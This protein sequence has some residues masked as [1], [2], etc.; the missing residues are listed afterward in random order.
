[1]QVEMK[2]KGLMLDPVT[3]MPI[4]ILY[5]MEGQRILPIH[6]AH[7]PN[8]RFSVGGAV[9][10]AAPDI[11]Q[12]DQIAPPCKILSPPFPPHRIMRKPGPGW[13][14]VNLYKGGIRFARFIVHRIDD[15]PSDG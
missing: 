9:A 8:I 6:A 11:G 13:P 1:M 3:N 5:D 2:I 15:M 10:A 14:A 4:I 7:I 12:K